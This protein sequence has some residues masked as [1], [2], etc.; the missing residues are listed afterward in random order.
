MRNKKKYDQDYHK[1]NLIRIPF[2]LNKEKDADILTYL[3]NHKP[4]QSEIK[5]LI[6]EAIK[7]EIADGFKAFCEREEIGFVGVYTKKKGETE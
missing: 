2:N 4:V 3:E 7:R 1:R 5:R 6:R